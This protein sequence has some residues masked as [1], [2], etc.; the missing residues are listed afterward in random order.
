MRRSCNSRPFAAQGRSGTRSHPPAA[1]RSAGSRRSPRGRSNRAPGRCRR[2][3]C[4]CDATEGV[5][6]AQLFADAREERVDAAVHHAR[7]LGRG[8]PR[9]SAAPGQASHVDDL[10]HRVLV[11]G[12][13][14]AAAAAAATT[15][16]APP[17][18]S[19]GASGRI[20]QDPG[21]ALDL[22]LA[23]RVQVGELRVRHLPRFAR[24]PR[25]EEDPEQETQAGEDA[26]G[27]QKLRHVG[28]ALDLRRPHQ[29]GVLRQRALLEAV[30]LH[31][32]DVF[33][34]LLDLASLAVVH[35]EQAVLP[36]HLALRD[37]LNELP[38]GEGPVIEVVLDDHPSRGVVLGDLPEQLAEVDLGGA[39]GPGGRLRRSEL[40]VERDASARSRRAGRGRERR[41]GSGRGLRRRRSPDRGDPRTLGRCRCRQRHPHLDA[42]RFGAVVLRQPAGGPE[43]LKRDSRG[44]ET[45]CRV[46]GEA[47][48]QHR[49]ERGRPFR[50]GLGWCDEVCARGPAGE[51]RVQHAPQPE[52]VRA[53]GRGLTA[54]DLGG[55]ARLAR[56]SEHGRPMGLEQGLR[57]PE[58]LDLHPAVLG[59]PDHVG[60]Q[61]AV[62]TLARVG[63]LERRFDLRERLDDVPERED[64][65]LRGAA[66]DDGRQGLPGDPFACDEAGAVLLDP[67]A[68]RGGDRPVRQRGRRS[69]LRTQRFCGGPRLEEPGAEHPERDRLLGLLVPR[70]DQGPEPVRRHGAVHLEAAAEHG[71]RRHRRAGRAGGSQRGGRCALERPTRI[72]LGG[73]VLRGQASRGRGNRSRR[74]AGA[75]PRAARASVRGG[76]RTGG[77][78]SRWPPTP[79]AFLG[80]RRAAVAQAVSDGVACSTRTGAS[81]RATST[82]RGRSSAVLPASWASTCSTESFGTP[83]NV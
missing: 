75:N 43:S 19:G 67:H 26:P 28:G 71:A 5:A 39:N 40:R 24:L 60:P 63:R 77:S 18:A 37:Q 9:L 45:L 54:A 21:G 69:D 12:P 74:R 55:K 51:R 38:A 80:G 64:R 22:H 16:R 29:G 65:S 23:A 32:L 62:V 33:R 8:K 31:E 52:H 82:T 72:R 27:D 61:R 35:V 1:A 3:P 25:V 15:A 42:A 7:H 14:A 6:S 79:R 30:L 81:A 76:M 4:R 49:V 17:R 83:T 56:G 44:R 10:V 53:G 46:G 34:P 50:V 73:H 20:R 66:R 68:I 36:E 2:W 41:A 57:E 47:L 59:D 48:E 11:R 58:L 13:A 78:R 70:R